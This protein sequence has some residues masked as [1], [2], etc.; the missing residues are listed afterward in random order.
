MYE[1]KTLVNPGPGR[2]RKKVMIYRS[3]L[4]RFP[5][6]LAKKKRLFT[7]ISDQ[8]QFYSCLPAIFVLF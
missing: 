1:G 4:G 6:G 5:L 2:G 3:R 8:Q 7:E